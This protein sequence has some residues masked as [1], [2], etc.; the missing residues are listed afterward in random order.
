MMHLNEILMQ[1]V[2]YKDKANF[3]LCEELK[4]RKNL[5]LMR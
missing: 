5:N 2:C 4:E 1:L 3:Q